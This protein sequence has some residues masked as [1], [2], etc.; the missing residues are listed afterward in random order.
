LEGEKGADEKMGEKRRLDRD[1][2]EGLEDTKIE[3]QLKKL[4]KKKQQ[5]LM[6]L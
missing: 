3:L 4:K 5:K 6:A 1:Q 2:E